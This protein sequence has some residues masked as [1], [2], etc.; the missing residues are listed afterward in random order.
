LL[1]DGSC[2]LAI[3]LMEKEGS[4]PSFEVSGV[5]IKGM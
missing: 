1:F 5:V 3:F 2:I 4:R